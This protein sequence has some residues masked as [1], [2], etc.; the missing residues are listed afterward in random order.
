MMFHILSWIISFAMSWNISF[1]SSFLWEMVGWTNQIFF[2]NMIYHL[3]YEQTLISQSWWIMNS[4]HTYLGLSDRE[5]SWIWGYQRFMRI[6]GGNSYE[7]EA[8]PI[9][10]MEPSK[11]WMNN[12]LMKNMITPCRIS[13]M[14]NGKEIENTPRPCFPSWNPS[15]D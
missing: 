7:I 1:N 3:S 4:H 2:T 13:W 6:L 15:I 9:C 12:I 11:D 10:E 5:L 14:E 8:L